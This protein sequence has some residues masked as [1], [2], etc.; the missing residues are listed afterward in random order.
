MRKLFFLVLSFVYVIGHVQNLKIQPTQLNHISV[1]A[2]EF[3]GID[4]I[5]DYFY[6][7]NNILYKKNALKSFQYQNINLGKLKKVDVINPLKIS[8]FYQEFN[9][10]ILLDSQLNEIQKI[11]LSENEK[12][13]L[14]T[15]VGTSGQNQLW[16]FNNLD[17]QIGLLDTNTNTNKSIGQPI[18]STI[19]YYQT[20]FN[21]FEWIDTENLWYSCTIYGRTNLVGKTDTNSQLQYV[22]ATNYIYKKGESLYLRDIQSLILYEIEIVE[23]SFKKFYYK[24]QIL[25]I[26][27]DQGITNYNITKPR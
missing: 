11:N 5:G 4:G 19:I 20:N 25:S 24:D 23:K 8:L 3:I 16:I 9:T 22:D 21:Y 6:I 26:F 15:A 27:T 13:I 7:K 1:E 18:K 14:A 17:Q 2:D 12:P 10:I